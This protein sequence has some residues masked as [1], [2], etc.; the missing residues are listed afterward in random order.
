MLHIGGF[1]VAMGEKYDQCP[2]SAKPHHQEGC[3]VGGQAPQVFFVPTATCI[4][5]ML[6]NSPEDVD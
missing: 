6:I 5:G 1:V 2:R 4:S 3:G